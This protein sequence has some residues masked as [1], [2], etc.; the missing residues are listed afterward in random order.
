MRPITPL[1]R[2]SPNSLGGSGSLCIALYEVAVRSARRLTQ[3]GC[4]SASGN[5]TLVGTDGATGVAV[6]G[7]PGGDAPYQIYLTTGSRSPHDR[8]ARR[9]AT[10]PR[11]AP[12]IRP[13]H[14][15]HPPHAEDRRVRPRRVAANRLHQ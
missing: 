11:R 3:A 2:G 1:S 8:T 10:R 14:S 5:V 4:H 9:A 6:G 15:A 12:R 13:A 7:T